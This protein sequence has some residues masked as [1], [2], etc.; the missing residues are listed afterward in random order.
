MQQYLEHGSKYIQYVNTKY[1]VLGEEKMWCF[2]K[3]LWHYILVSVLKVQSLTILWGHP[4]IMHS[5]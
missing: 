4:A 2:T 5:G 1:Q 3:S